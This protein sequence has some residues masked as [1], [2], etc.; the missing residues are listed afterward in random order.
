[1][2]LLLKNVSVILSSTHKLKHKKNIASV[3]YVARVSPCLRDCRHLEFNVTVFNTILS[4]SVLS[5]ISSLHNNI[6]FLHFF[7]DDNAT[8]MNFPL[9][10]LI[11]R[12]HQV[13]YRYY[14]SL[15]TP[16]CYESVLWTVFQSPITISKRQ[17]CR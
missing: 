1:M 6:Y 8:L 3:L 7:P 12:D 9:I 16:P 11:P 2:M 5:R 13:Y 10:S 15:T 14:G 17:V 4:L